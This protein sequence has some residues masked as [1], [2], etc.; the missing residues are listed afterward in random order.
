LYEFEN[1]VEIVSAAKKEN[2]QKIVSCAVGME[3]MRKSMDFSEI[4]GVF[5]CFGVHPANCL[6]MNEMEIEK[7]LEFIESNSKKCIGIGE[8]GLDFKY[9]QSFGQKEKQISLFKK[10]IALSEKLDLPIVVHSRMARKEC[11]E[12]LLENNAEKVLLHWFSGSKS[13]LEKIVE[14]NF[15]ISVGPSVMF[16][17]FSN[18]FVREIPLQNLLL[19]TDSPVMFSGKKSFPQWIPK[20][21]EKVAELKKV[22]IGEIEKETFKNA[23]NLFG[24]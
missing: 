22:S 20:V 6:S 3:S 19:E 4:E 2:V 9:A 17:G 12:L 8:I 23:Q 14:K 13:L 5:N 11:V 16:N 18:D 21:A 7:A 10:Q 15:F 1:P 24:F